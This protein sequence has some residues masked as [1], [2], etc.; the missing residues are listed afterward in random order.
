[1]ISQVHNFILMDG[2]DHGLHVLTG[3]AM[4]CCKLWARW[5]G[6]E[7]NMDLLQKYDDDNQKF[8]A[9]WDKL[10]DGSFTM[11][12]PSEVIYLAPGDLHATVTLQ[13]GLTPGIEYF[14][15]DSVQMTYEMW[16][17]EKEDAKWFIGSCDVGL[18]NEESRLQTAKVLCL[19][20]RKHAELS[21]VPWFKSLARREGN[22]GRS[23]PVCEEAWEYHG[24]EPNGGS[25]VGDSSDSE[26]EDVRRGYYP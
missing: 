5:P 15:T 11:T 7:H 6:T 13:G 9:L 21:Q 25:G 26:F 1:M 3:G 23:C 12:R 2:M 17:R 10:T 19:A 22:A 8:L 24:I 4:G 14:S 16:R 20:L 18:K